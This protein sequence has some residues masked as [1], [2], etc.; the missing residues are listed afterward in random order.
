MPVYEA[1]NMT[2]DETYEQVQVCL[3]PHRTDY[4]SLKSIADIR[5]TVS[6]LN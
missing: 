6:R 5:R 2:G 3:R 4:N 1:D